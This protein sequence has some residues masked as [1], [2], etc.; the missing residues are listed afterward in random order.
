MRE[1]K[2]LFGNRSGPEGM[3]VTRQVKEGGQCGHL[4]SISTH[5]EQQAIQSDRQKPCC[6]WNSANIGLVCL[7]ALLCALGE[8]AAENG[9]SAFHSSSLKL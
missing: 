2:S 6:H 7:H 8:R 9:K 5:Y 4:F 3:D 1:I